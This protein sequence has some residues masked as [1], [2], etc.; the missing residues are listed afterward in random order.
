MHS[1][2]LSTVVL[3]HSLP[4]WCSELLQLP[5]S[6]HLLS[7]CTNASVGPPSLSKL[8]TLTQQPSKFVNGLTPFPT[9]T[10]HRLINTANLLCPC[11]LVSQL[12]CRM[13]F[14]RFE[15]PPQW[16]VSYP[17]TATRYAPAMVLFTT[18]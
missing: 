12:P 6:H 15:S 5:S 10:D 17:R 4:S 8:A 9:L 2:M 14:T 13:L 18:T 1:N 11:M 3:I 7:S 16:Y